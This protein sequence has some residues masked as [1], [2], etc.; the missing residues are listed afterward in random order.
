V[1]DINLFLRGWAAYCASR[2]CARLIGGRW[3]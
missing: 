2:G 3:V 1:W